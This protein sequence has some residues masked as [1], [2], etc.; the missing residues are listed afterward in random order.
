M[1]SKTTER[2]NKFYAKPIPGTSPGMALGW[3]SDRGRKTLDGVRQP[4]RG[5][6]HSKRNDITMDKSFTQ[7]RFP[8]SLCVEVSFWR[9]VP[10]ETTE[11]WERFYAK[12]IPGTIP[13]MALG[14]I[15]DRGR[16]RKQR[17]Q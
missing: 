9:N 12:P 11:R 15:S 16:G 4:T 5:R 8:E 1:P 14:W 13:G 10:C 17:P 2:W 7:R 3:I 6:D